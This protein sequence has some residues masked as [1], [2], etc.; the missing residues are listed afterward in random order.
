MALELKMLD[1][2]KVRRLASRDSD[3]KAPS[4]TAAQIGGVNELAGKTDFT[5]A[6]AIVLL[7]CREI[8]VEIEW[9]KIKTRDCGWPNRAVV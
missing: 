6:Q 4:F 1:H 7:L 9:V 5:L 3:S 8:L 2:I